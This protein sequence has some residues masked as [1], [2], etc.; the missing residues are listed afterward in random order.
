MPQPA[1]V[2]GVTRLRR[3]PTA[4]Q[5]ASVLL[6]AA[7]VLGVLGCSR[8]GD[9]VSRAAFEQALVDEYAISNEEADC[10]AGYAFSEY[11]PA[12]IRRL[13]EGGLTSLAPDRWSAYA[14]ALLACS[15]RSDLFGE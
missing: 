13:H 15:L 10:V 6:V 14:Q 12:E 8:S 1:S 11:G 9:D 5:L 7:S 4:R 2:V 3:V